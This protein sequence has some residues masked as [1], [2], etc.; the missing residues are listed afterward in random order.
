MLSR[1]F[2]VAESTRLAGNRSSSYGSGRRWMEN[3][4]R[5]RGRLETTNVPHAREME[6]VCFLTRRRTAGAWTATQR[7]NSAWMTDRQPQESPQATLRMFKCLSATMARCQPHLTGCASRVQRTARKSS[8]SISPVCR[9]SN[10]FPSDSAIRMEN[11]IRLGRS[12]R[13]GR[14]MPDSS[15]LGLTVAA[16]HHQRWNTFSWIWRPNGGH[17]R[18]PATVLCGCQTLRTSCLPHHASWCRCRVR[19]NGTSGR[20]TLPF[21]TSRLTRRRR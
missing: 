13:P 19:G 10:A 9:R 18:S 16:A 20:N 1:W 7:L 21:T 11:A 15:S 14:L 2:S 17:V 5:S 3:W 4:S 6:R 8:S 12:S